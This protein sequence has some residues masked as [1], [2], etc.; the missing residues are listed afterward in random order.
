MLVLSDR[1]LDNVRLNSESTTPPFSYG[2]I[3]YHTTCFY[4]LSL[5]LVFKHLSFS[6]ATAAPYA[7]GQCHRS[8]GRLRGATGEISNFYNLS[9]RLLVFNT[10]IPPII[11][12]HTQNFVHVCLIL[13][14][15]W[16]FFKK[17]L[18][19]KSISS[20]KFEKYDLDFFT[21]SRIHLEKTTYP[22]LRNLFRE[23]RK[24]INIF[25]Q[26]IILN[27]SGVCWREIIF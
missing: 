26:N 24:K 13:F 14:E 23:E 16:F 10:H 5:C 2:N 21:I 25:S 20:D 15:L 6:W 18:F 12:T 27:F 1:L 19:S 3:W 8:I 7:Q 9:V 17:G 11:N 22:Y 4:P